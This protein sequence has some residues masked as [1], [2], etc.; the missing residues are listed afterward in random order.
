MGIM[1]CRWT[2]P[3]SGKDIVAW[4]DIDSPHFTL[5]HAFSN[6]LTYGE[7]MEI[8]ETHYHNQNFLDLDMRCSY[9]RNMLNVRKP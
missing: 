7:R 9:W 3:A 4:A 1:I 5:S 2:D 6:F 8:L